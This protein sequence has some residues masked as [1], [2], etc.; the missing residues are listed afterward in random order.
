VPNF[1]PAATAAQMTTTFEVSFFE[2][3]HITV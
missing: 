3:E 1:H 2:G